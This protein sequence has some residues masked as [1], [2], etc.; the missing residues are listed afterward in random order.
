M[1][2][3]RGKVS[4]LEADLRSSASVNGQLQEQ[5]VQGRRGKDKL[6]KQLEREK[7]DLASQVG[8]EQKKMEG[9]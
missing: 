3:L 8:E 2:A 9:S 4:S 7:E 5:M 6:I 1:E